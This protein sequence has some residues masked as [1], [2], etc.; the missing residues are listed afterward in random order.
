MQEVVPLL[1]EL[2]TMMTADLLA[3]SD[4]EAV[5]QEL[6]RFLRRSTYPGGCQRLRSCIVH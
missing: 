2:K 3:R 6:E 5:D 4:W 1:A